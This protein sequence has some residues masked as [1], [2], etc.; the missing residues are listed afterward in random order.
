MQRHWWH[1][2]RQSF[3]FYPNVHVSC[4]WSEPSPTLQWKLMV[5][6]PRQ[7]PF[8]VA[9]H[10]CKMLSPCLAS[11]ISSCG[12]S[13]IITPNRMWVFTGHHMLLLQTRLLCI[14][15][16]V[17]STWTAFLL[18]RFQSSQVDFPLPTASLG[19]RRRTGVCLWTG[20]SLV[21]LGLQC[22]EELAPAA[23]CQTYIFRPVSEAISSPCV[24]INAYRD[25]APCLKLQICAAEEERS[26]L[27]SGNVLK[28]GILTLHLL[29]SILILQPPGGS[30]HVALL[31][32][33]IF[34]SCFGDRRDPSLKDSLF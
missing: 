13:D 18:P 15:A 34:F 2:G 16:P 10:I 28:I 22:L 25:T 33:I 27:P 6:W 19:R 30:W 23:G 3:H 1:A 26:H 20:D 5:T 7:L 31:F 8:V 9:G 4:L 29:V 11:L 32:I 21:C 12:C 24:A 17:C 14:C